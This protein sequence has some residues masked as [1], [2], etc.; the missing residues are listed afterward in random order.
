MT[1]TGAVADLGP[2]APPTIVTN[3]IIA[4][5]L[6]GPCRITGVARARET[7]VGTRGARGC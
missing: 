7:V 1:P 2:V 3:L 5:M 4:L 6:T